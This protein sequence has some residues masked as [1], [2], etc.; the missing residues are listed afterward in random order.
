MQTYGE[1]NLQMIAQKLTNIAILRERVKDNVTVMIVGLNRGFKNEYQFWLK[2]L[3]SLHEARLCVSYIK[4]FKDVF[5][6]DFAY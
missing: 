5:S 1:N 3:K 4:L 6:R 2:L